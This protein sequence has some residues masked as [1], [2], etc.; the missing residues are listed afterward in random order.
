MHHRRILLLASALLA[1]SLAWISP[2]GAQDAGIAGV[3][4]GTYTCA[5]GVTGL[6][7][8]VAGAGEAVTASF[9]FFADPS[10]PG[11]P[12]GAYTMTGRYDTKSRAL[13]LRQERW[14]EQPPGYIMV[15]LDGTLSAD[16]RTVTGRIAN[17][18]C[19]DFTVS[20]AAK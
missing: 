9:E 16:G 19:S 5:Q 2:A 15:D 13:A 11:I 8:R 17:E 20:R 3:W 7:L 4:R 18:N 12:S 10:N 6:I 1:L 14:V